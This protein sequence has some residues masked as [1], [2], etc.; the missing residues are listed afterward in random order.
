MTKLMTGLLCCWRRR[1][2]RLHPWAALG[3][4]AQQPA[5]EGVGGGGHAAGG[6][7][8]RLTGTPHDRWWVGGAAGGGP[9]AARGWCIETRPCLPKAYGWGLAVKLGGLPA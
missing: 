6:A 7:A 3:P 2:L 9:Q 5:C 4:W 1:A 8:V